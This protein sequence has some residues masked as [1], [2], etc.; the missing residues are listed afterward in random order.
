[1]GLQGRSSNNL[2]TSQHGRPE[3]LFF[4]SMHHSNGLAAGVGPIPSLPGDRR[5][6]GLLLLL[7]VLQLWRFPLTCGVLPDSPAQFQ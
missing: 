3:S 1:M 6:Q 5:S 2:P 7:L 4:A